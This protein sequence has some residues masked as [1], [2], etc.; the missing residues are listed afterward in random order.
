[1]KRGSSRRLIDLPNSRSA[2]A[3][4]IGVPLL[5]GRHVLSGPLDRLD[6]VVITRAPAEVALEL[7][8]DLLLA[9]V[10]IALEHLV[11]RHDHARRAEAALEPVLL[12]EPLLDGVELAV[13][14]EALDGGDGGAVSLHGEER[15]RLHRHA[16]HEDDAGAALARVAADV[17]ARQTDDFSDVVDEKQSWLDFVAVRLAVDGDLD[18]QF[19]GASSGIRRF[20]SDGVLARQRVS[21]TPA[22]VNGVRTG[23][24]GT[25]TRC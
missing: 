20:V 25:P 19:H 9:R 10:R 22:P 3:G 21:R 12:P 23:G 4:A 17:G 15:A 11:R 6:D 7:V 16:F 14:G 18:W 13:L 5:P 2:A 1:M 24:S 8:P